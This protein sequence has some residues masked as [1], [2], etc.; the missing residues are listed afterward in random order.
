MEAFIYYPAT[1]FIKPP[2]KCHSS[3]SREIVGVIA[4]IHESIIRIFLHKGFKNGENCLTGFCIKNAAFIGIDL[5]T[6]KPKHVHFNIVAFLTVRVH[7][8]ISVD[9]NEIFVAGLIYESGGLPILDK[10]IQILQ[11]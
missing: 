1:F 9:V 7:Q 4:N 2:A 3:V 5:F 10:I 11:T 6:I 8:E